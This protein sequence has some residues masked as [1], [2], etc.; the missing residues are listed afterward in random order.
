MENIHPSYIA[1]NED[2]AAYK[3]YA[4][5]GMDL[6]FPVRMKGRSHRPDINVPYHATIKLFDTTK[7][8]PEHA[9]EVASKLSLN[10]PDPKNVHIEPTTLKGRNGNVMHVIKLHG[11]HAEEIKAHHAKFAHLGYR[12]NYQYSPHVTVD[13]HTWNHIVNSK[14][15]TAHEA[16]MEFMPAEL[17]HKEKV[18]ASYKPKHAAPFGGEHSG[19]DKLAASEKLSLVRETIGLNV[20]LQKHEKAVQLNDSFLL[21]YLQDNPELMKTIIEKHEKRLEHHFGDNKKLV[22]IAWK[23]GMQ[24]AYKA[25]DKK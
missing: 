1:K 7:D 17:H 12:E 14:A 5:E 21:N 19:T 25:K 15:K 6:M 16:G 23:K 10:P 9:H 18:V 13:E 22:D 8:K 24:E 20:D 3:K 11:P 4:S 2:L